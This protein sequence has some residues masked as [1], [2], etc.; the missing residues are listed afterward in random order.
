MIQALADIVDNHPSFTLK[1]IRETVQQRMPDLN[2]SLSSIDRL[3]DS[4]GY[5]VKLLTSQPAYR[6]RS[7]VK[8][9]R[10]DYATWLETTG[11]TLLRFYVD[12]TNYTS[13]AV[14][15]SADPDVVPW[16]DVK[17]PALREPT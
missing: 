9:L 3:L 12:E 2:I 1:Q 11:P 7:D 15:C 8:L 14:V 17:R 13:G 4:H 16:H 6:N 10:R 5:S